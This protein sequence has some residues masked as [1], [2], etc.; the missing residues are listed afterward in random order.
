MEPLHLQQDSLFLS[1]EWVRKAVGLIEKAKASDEDVRNLTSEFSLSV[2]YVIDQLPEGL[3]RI[4]GG[5]KVAIYI[6]Q[7]CNQGILYR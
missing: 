6:E 4:Y 7:W 1:D 5:D 2:A 3:K